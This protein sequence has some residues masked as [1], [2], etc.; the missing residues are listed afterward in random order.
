MIF[1]QWSLFCALPAI[2]GIYVKNKKLS[3][4]NKIL[5]LHVGVLISIAL[6]SIVGVRLTWQPSSLSLALLLL[7]VLAS[8]LLLGKYGFLYIVSTFMQEWNIL[9]SASYLAGGYGIIFAALITAFVFILPHQTLANDLVWKLPLL[10]V[11]GCAS[12]FLYVWLGEPLLNVAIHAT[13]GS[14]LIYKRILYWPRTEPVRIEEK[15]E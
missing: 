7:S 8:F 3:P 4:K 14:I 15:G 12:F 11:W 5:I 2:V 6:F 10:F 13:G 9:L 1:L